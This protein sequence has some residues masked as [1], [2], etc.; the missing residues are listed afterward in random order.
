MTLREIFAY[1]R[2]SAYDSTAFQRGCRAIRENALTLKPDDIREI[3]TLAE[4]VRAN[5]YDLGYFDLDAE[6]ESLLKNW[7]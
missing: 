4:K 1:I 2:F 6:V 3:K 5:H 7:R